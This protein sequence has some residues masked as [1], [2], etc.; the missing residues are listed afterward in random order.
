MVPRRPVTVNFVAD[1]GRP[2]AS[3][4]RQNAGENTREAP[5]LATSWPHLVRSGKL[6]KAYDDVSVNPEARIETRLK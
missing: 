3:D 6:V 2:I 5:H 1:A 4:Y